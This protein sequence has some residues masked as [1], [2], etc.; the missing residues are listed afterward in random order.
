MVSL[1]KTA[2]EYSGGRK[3]KGVELIAL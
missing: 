3:Q 2:V 1:A